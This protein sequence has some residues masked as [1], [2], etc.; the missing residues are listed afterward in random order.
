M[1]VYTF[2][3][4]YTLLVGGQQTPDPAEGRAGQTGNVHI[5]WQCD[6]LSGTVLPAGASTEFEQKGHSGRNLEKERDTG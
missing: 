6:A 1:P 5:A 4:G 3:S 2:M